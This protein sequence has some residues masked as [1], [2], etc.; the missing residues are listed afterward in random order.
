MLQQI[1]KGRCFRRTFRVIAVVVGENVFSYFHMISE[2][3]GFNE[4]AYP[5]LSKNG[6]TLAVFFLET[7]EE[8]RSI[9]EWVVLTAE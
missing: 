4:I 5:R 2:K 8:P 6:L 1:L 9:G 7:I 3:I